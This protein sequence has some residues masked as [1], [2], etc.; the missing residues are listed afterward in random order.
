V[1]GIAKYKLTFEDN[2]KFLGWEEEE[3]EEKVKET[4]EEMEK[5]TNDQIV[6]S[7][8]KN[9]KMKCEKLS[10][11]KK[12]YNFTKTRVDKVKVRATKANLGKLK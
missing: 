3:E 2:L 5:G 4:K 6:D 10:I 12:V 1:S 9:F 7:P 8:L 11:V